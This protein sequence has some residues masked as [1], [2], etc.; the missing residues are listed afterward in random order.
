LQEALGASLDAAL[1][2]PELDC[3]GIYLVDAPSGVK[4][5]VHQGV[6]PTFIE[7]V[8]DFDNDSSEARIVRE[9]KPVYASLQTLP[10][11]IYSACER[12]GL[13]S[14][15]FV[16]ICHEGRAIGCLNVASR[17]LDEVPESV[18]AGLETTVSYAG[19]AVARIQADQSR[20]KSEA[21]FRALVEN[22]PDTVMFTDLESR[23]LYINHTHSEAAVDSVVGTTGM[24]YFSPDQHEEILQ[25]HRLAIES[26]QV[27]P[28][29]C[30]DRWGH[31]WLCRA[32]P[33]LENGEVR[34]LMVIT[35]DVTDKWRAE[36]ELRKSEERFR[37]IAE[38]VSDVVWTLQIEGLHEF[39]TGIAADPDL[40]HLDELFERAQFT[41]FSPS[42]EQVLGYSVDEALRLKPLT[43]IAPSSHLVLRNGFLDTIASVQ[44]NPDYVGGREAVELEHV[45]RDGQRLWCELTAK[46]F[47]DTQGRVI[48]LEGV[49]RDVSERKSFERE[50]SAI[51][52]HEQQRMGQQLHDELGQQL[53]GA[54]L[55]SES[56]QRVL[57]PQQ[58]SATQQAREL[59]EALEKAQESVRELIKGIRPVEIDAEGLMAALDDLAS[60]TE[61]L[62]GIHCSFAHSERVPV[63]DNHTA[64]QLFYIAREAV[65]NAVKHAAP[66]KITIGL[67]VTHGV[68]RLWVSDDG[69]GIRGRAGSSTSGMGLRIM[70]YRA[71]V[72]GAQLMIDPGKDGG[73][74]ITCSLL[75][76][77]VP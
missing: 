72:I 47:R 46:L 67:A 66:R 44:E 15:G 16:P 27:Q 64:T 71:G 61:R 13:K 52:T 33:R 22:M 24:Q 26:R 42:V 59:H 54:R 69:V 48:G 21:R 38:N 63:E 58:S 18:R 68:L 1:E 35:T 10:T 75:M 2:L 28:F 74:R 4:L 25:A 56:L 5:A 14:V 6:S 3:G 37:L 40:S 76:E 53:V 49:T 62:S 34:G 23:I 19:V 70:R 7:A 51:I 9:G 43:L 45:K 31:R 65:L 77:Q 39:A 11:E 50:L 41:F 73:T 12:E 30:T 17:H 20:L 8:T 32:V 57:R 36:E 60:S 29:D 55:M